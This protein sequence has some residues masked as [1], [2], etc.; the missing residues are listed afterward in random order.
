[1]GVDVVPSVCRSCAGITKGKR[2]VDMS[3]VDEETW[4]QGC[5][6]VLVQVTWTC[7]SRHCAPTARNV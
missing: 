6:I 4:C 5:M 1:M 7:L 3:T 2:F